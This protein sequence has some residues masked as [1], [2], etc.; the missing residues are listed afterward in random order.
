MTLKLA[1]RSRCIMKKKRKKP[2][3]RPEDFFGR[4]IQKDPAATDDEEEEGSKDCEDKKE[5]KNR[6]AS[7]YH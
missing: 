3:S 4:V 6:R 5:D 7:Q 2:L 1:Q